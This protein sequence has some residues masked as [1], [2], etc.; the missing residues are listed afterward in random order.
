[1]LVRAAGNGADAAAAMM[2]DEEDEESKSLSEILHE[3]A[4]AI[5]IVLY[6]IFLI[7]FTA[8]AVGAGGVSIA[9]LDDV[10]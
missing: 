2:D 3:N 4:F 5:E 7:L 1:M 9:P 6:L 10:Q 8:Y